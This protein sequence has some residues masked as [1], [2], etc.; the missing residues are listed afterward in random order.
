MCGITSLGGVGVGGE[1]I[2]VETANGEKV[3]QKMNG[4]SVSME[5]VLL[6]GEAMAKR[7]PIFETQP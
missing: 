5:D 2:K 4:S 6:D 1:I 7:P 3:E